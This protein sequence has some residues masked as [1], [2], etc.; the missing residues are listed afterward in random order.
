MNTCAEA[1]TCRYTCTSMYL[2]RSSGIIRSSIKTLAWLL[3]RPFLQ[4]SEWS[5]SVVEVPS[6]QALA[7]CL[8]WDAFLLAVGVMIAHL[9]Y[10]RLP[11]SSNQFGQQGVFPSA[12]LSLIFSHRSLEILETVVCENLRR[13]PASEIPKPA[14]LAPKSMSTSEF[15]SLHFS[16]GSFWSLMWSS[17]ETPDLHECRCTGCVH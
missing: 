2:C 4:S 3:T 12:E 13:S 16:F 1:H 6:P 9:G 7:W 8:C 14:H 15:L 17:S 11:F 5:S 10:Y